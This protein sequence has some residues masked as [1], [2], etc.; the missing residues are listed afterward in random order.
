[1]SPAEVRSLSLAGE[2]TIQT[3]AEEKA[4]LLA[5]LETATAAHTDV[6]LDLSD[7]SELDTAGVQLL[8]MARRE[9]RAQGRNLTLVA[10]S[11][12]ALEVLRIAHL[13]TSLEPVGPH[14][15]QEAGR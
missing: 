7:V 14:A 2:L 6:E 5:F 8:L 3:A 9:A 1:V 15:T 11:H 10:P 4:A 13:D 12:T